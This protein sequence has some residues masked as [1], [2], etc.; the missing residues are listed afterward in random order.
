MGESPERK[1]DDWKCSE[2][3]ESAMKVTLLGFENS[4]AFH[5][6]ESDAMQP[7]S[8]L[9]IE[10]SGDTIRVWEQ[11]PTIGLRCRCA[12]LVMTGRGGTRKV[13]GRGWA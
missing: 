7:I 2:T 4:H 13:S 6:G 11:G 3:R 5:V 8:D 1:R 12:A 9:L 10:Q